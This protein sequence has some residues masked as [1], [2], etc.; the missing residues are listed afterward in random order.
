MDTRE[1]V[2]AIEAS[3]PDAMIPDRAL[4][5]PIAIAPRQGRVVLPCRWE[6]FMAMHGTH[7]GRFKI[8]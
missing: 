6:A 3:S 5:R 2:V 4:P 7:I 1:V 8:R